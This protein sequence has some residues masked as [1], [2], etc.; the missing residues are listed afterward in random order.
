MSSPSARKR[1]AAC[2]S[3]LPG[4]T[5]GSGAPPLPSQTLASARRPSPNARTRNAPNTTRLPPQA[6]DRTPAP[7]PLAAATSPPNPMPDPAATPPS[8]RNP[9]VRAARRTVAGRR[10]RRTHVSTNTG[11]TPCRRSDARRLTADP[12]RETRCGTRTPGNTRNRS[13]DT[14][15]DVQPPRPGVPTQVRVAT[16]AD[17]KLRT[18]RTPGASDGSP[19]PV[20]DPAG[21]TPP[22]DDHHPAL[23]C[24]VT[25]TPTAPNDSRLPQKAVAAMAMRSTPDRNHAAAV[26][27][28]PAAETTPTP[29]PGAACPPLRHPSRRTTQRTCPPPTVNRY[30][31]WPHRTRR[32]H[33]ASNPALRHG[34]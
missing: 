9:A 1:Y 24:R 19:V 21:G 18:P 12:T 16:G 27:A 25:R 29:P 22:A 28:A 32:P 34:A 8:V 10:T 5:A 11:P 7:E 23:R 13:L 4:K 30:Q 3:A 33:T 2:C 17:T 26:P 15:C 31:L 20:T 6:P 14:T